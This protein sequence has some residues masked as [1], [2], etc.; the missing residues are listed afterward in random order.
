[1]NRLQKNMKF[2][3][4]HRLQ[5]HDGQCKNL[6]GHT[7]RVEV[8]LT[9]PVG[10]NGMILDFSHLKK[11]MSSVIDEFDHATIIQAGDTELIKSVEGQKFKHVILPEDPTAEYLSKYIDWELAKKFDSYEIPMGALPGKIRILTVKV[12]ESDTAASSYSENPQN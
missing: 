1:M 5:S 9:G 10:D 6:H 11:I 8:V 3:A 2:D 7:W 12:W 4:A